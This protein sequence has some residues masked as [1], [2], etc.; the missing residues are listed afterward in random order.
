MKKIIFILGILLIL[1]PAFLTAQVPDLFSDMNR[2]FDELDGT[3]PFYFPMDE[4]FLGRAAA[5]SIVSIYGI[6]TGNPQL[7][8]YLNLICQALV[9]NSRDYPIAFR[10]YRV[11][12][13]NSPQINALSTPSGHI[14]LTRGLIQA[15]PSEDALAAVIAHELAHIMLRHS[16]RIIE[17]DEGRMLRERDR[18]IDRAGTLFGTRVNNFGIAV[19]RLNTLWMSRLTSDLEYEAD[20]VAVE[21]LVGAGY[22]ANGLIEMLNILNGIQASRLGESFHTH[23]MPSQRIAR[24]T[25]VMPSVSRL[26]D[27]SAT[28]TARFN[29]ITGR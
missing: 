5:A 9:I 10:G 23:P 29:R 18:V 16:I 11:S 3:G 26:P 21:L 1:S 12:I 20:I 15:A 2:M 28:R 19:N 6:Y 27:N 7:T 14:F 22:N 25:R 8:R 13:L 24:L 17:S 4:Y